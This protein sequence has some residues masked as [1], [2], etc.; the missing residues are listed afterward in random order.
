MSEYIK[1]LI[2]R[3]EFYEEQKIKCLNNSINRYHNHEKRS[4]YYMEANEYSVRIEELQKVLSE[5]NN[6]IK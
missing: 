1:I 5:I 4:S 3:I 6:R 2:N